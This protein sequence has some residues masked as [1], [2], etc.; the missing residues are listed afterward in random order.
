M[1]KYV[2]MIVFMSKSMT[3]SGEG[4]EMYTYF[5]I[6][7]NSPNRARKLADKWCWNLI[8]KNPSLK[9]MYKSDITLVERGDVD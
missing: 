5:T 4:I 7:A 6:N 9:L 3:K 1:Q 2:F 8:N